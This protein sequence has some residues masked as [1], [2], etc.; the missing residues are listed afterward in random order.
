MVPFLEKKRNCFS[1]VTAVTEYGW[2]IS[3]NS[4]NTHKHMHTR[5]HMHMLTDYFLVFPLCRKIPA[6]EEQI[7]LHFLIFSHLPSW[8]GV[9]GNPT[10]MLSIH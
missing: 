7:E 8:L 10:L 4:P 5:T 2:R 9:S 3:G 1:F 6:E